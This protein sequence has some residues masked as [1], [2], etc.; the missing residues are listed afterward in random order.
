M[1]I[2]AISLLLFLLISIFGV[3]F[4]IVRNLRE[5]LADCS[6]K[7]RVIAIVAMVFSAIFLLRPHEDT[8]AGLDNSGYRLMARA[9]QAG[10]TMHETDRVLMEAPRDIRN[11]FMLL[12]SMKE[13]N[14]R[15]RSFLVKSL[16][17]CETEPFFYPLLPLCAVGFDAIV[18]GDALDYLV[19]VIG[20]LFSA[21]V[22]LVGMA[23]GSWLGLILAAALLVGSPL[24]AWLLRG[25]YVE[26]VASVLLTLALLN[27][28]TCPEGK[29]I[30]RFSYL[31]LGLAISFHPAM[32]VVS[33]PL[34][35]L[36]VLDLNERLK[37]ISAG[38]VSFGIGFVV[39]I[40]MAMYA[41]SPYGH[42]DWFG[43]KHNFIVSASHR[44]TLACAGLMIIV[45][46]VA[47]L[48]KPV[49]SGWYQKLS[50]RNRHFVTCLPLM[51]SVIPI[52]FSAMLW[53]QKTFVCRGLI[54]AGSGVRL[55]LGS[56][57]I[58]AVG[59]ILVSRRNVRA[60]MALMVV[61]LAFPVFAYLK[62]AEQMGLWSQ[63]R[64]LP[65]YLIAVVGILP[66]VASWLQTI[67][68]KAPKPLHLVTG[69]IA[70]LFLLIAGGSNLFRWP[71]PYTVRCDRGAWDWVE[72]VRARIEN[73]L[74]FFDYY[75]Y[76][77][78]F[79]VT[80]RT[81]VLGL[82]E[83]AHK[84]VAEIIRWLAD[85]AYK[86]EV[87]IATAYQ[88]PG[89]E[90]EIL[91][92]EVFS[93]SFKL[94]KVASKGAL[95]AE[96]RVQSVDIRFLSIKPVTGGT[97][98]PVLNKVFD[99]GPLA[100]R[101]AWGREMPIKVDGKMLPARW[102]REESGVVGPV[103][104]PGQAVR[105]SIDGAADRDDG[106]DGQVLRIKPPWNGTALSLVVSND[107]SS[108]SGT[109]SRGGD[110]K[111]DGKR[112]GIYRIYADKPYD[113]AKTGVKGYEN[114]LGAKIHLIRIEAVKADSVK[115]T[116]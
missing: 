27:W 69:G 78:P 97:S 88:N 31:A 15:D 46:A 79:A 70:V 30:S 95:P 35:M 87:L 114:D 99:E 13:R 64:L 57:L 109:L 73:R 2:L 32:I 52:T 100:I 84:G 106:V 23:Y 1:N 105:I 7:V 63:R 66:S 60:R 38:V 94:G 98:L 80:G 41:C 3:T 25:F 29:R 53:S 110:Q 116:G 67:I 85:K 74:V 22:L 68:Q 71:A 82:C 113:P 33:L 4:G 51:L 111:D 39:M 107:F 54:E 9:F 112:T 56:L 104:L 36:F 61:L 62:G 96:K 10:R 86:E 89:M 108:V 43:I 93:K 28:L 102:S 90:E 59:Y 26:S 72:N 55:C 16:D 12:P 8:F 101:G 49:W 76:S 75:P 17:K 5:R 19:P 83:R 40:G 24:P 77:V 34:L 18:P 103:P 45:T 6:T 47:V 42:L 91:L 50:E 14:T 65:V 48:T 21:V 81:R 11:K 44:I 20:L 37:D 58:L 115:P 92:N